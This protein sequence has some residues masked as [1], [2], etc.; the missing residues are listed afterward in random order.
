MEAFHYRSFS[1]LRLVLDA[2]GAY[3]ESIYHLIFHLEPHCHSI[4]ATDFAP[5]SQGLT[6]QSTASQCVL[7][8]WQPLSWLAVKAL[9]HLGYP[10]HYSHSQCSWIKK[11]EVI[12][13]SLVARWDL[14]TESLHKEKFSKCI[15]R[16][17]LPR[18]WGH[19]ISSF[20]TRG[21]LSSSP[22][23]PHLS[24]IIVGSQ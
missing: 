19:I 7:R 20:R 2:Q 22:C 23:I 21:V 11:R 3:M 9:N 15:D 1:P 14:C 10:Y 6:P 13:V 12:S 24:L 8:Q 17:R 18:Q 16:L 5:T 4:L